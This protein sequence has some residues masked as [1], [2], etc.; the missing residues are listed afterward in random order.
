MSRA[1]RG[2][3]LQTLY[4]LIALLLTL[5]LFLNEIFRKVFFLFLFNVQV[6]FRVRKLSYRWLEFSGKCA[7]ET[8]PTAKPYFVEVPK[9]E[10][11]LGR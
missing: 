8:S 11:N 2:A 6:L 10:R 4:V 1:E 7:R 3:L 5:S 9:G